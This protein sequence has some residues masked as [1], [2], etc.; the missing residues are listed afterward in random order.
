M[1]SEYDTFNEQ[2]LVWLRND[3]HEDHPDVVADRSRQTRMY[4]ML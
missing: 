2:Q 1:M 4:S 3:F